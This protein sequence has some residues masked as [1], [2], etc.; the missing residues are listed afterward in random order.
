MK[1]NFVLIYSTLN[2]ME[3]HIIKFLFDNNGI[4]TIIDNDRMNFF[5]GI[6]SAQDAMTDVWVPQNK[7]RQAI[8][9]LREKS[10][11]D[12][13][14]FKES[15]CP[16]CGEINCGLFDYCW[17]CTADLKTGE[18]HDEGRLNTNTT[19]EASHKH[20]L[21]LFI[22]II[23]MALLAAGYLVYMYY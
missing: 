6:V 12:P 4:E 17:K 20:L 18:L 1:N 9:L 23:L 3:A 10:S 5:F 19:G 21:P 13:A 15:A 14:K 22:L 7:Y 16:R 11:L 2:Q 8:D